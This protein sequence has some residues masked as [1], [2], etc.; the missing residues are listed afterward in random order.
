ML[1][2][3]V[4]F[5]L[6]VLYPVTRA[7]GACG[8]DVVVPSHGITTFVSPNYP[9]KYPNKA[10]C[11]YDIVAPA[12]STIELDSIFFMVEGGTGVT[13]GFDSLTVTETF[14]NGSVVVLGKFCSHSGPQSLRSATNRVVAT[15]RSDASW[16]TFGFNISARVPVCEPGSRLCPNSDTVCI[17][18]EQYC[19]GSENCPDGIDENEEKCQK[20]RCGRPAITPKTYHNYIGIHPRQRLARKTEI[21][22]RIV[23]GEES[24]PHSWPWQ[25]ALLDIR[26]GRQSCGGSIVSNEWILTAGHCCKAV[27]AA[28]PVPSDFKVLVG[29][30]VLRSSSQQQPFAEVIPLSQ[31]HIH[32]DYDKPLPFANDVCLLKL[33]KPVIFNEHIS[34]A[35]LS[36]GS[37]KTEQA[38][39]IVIGWGETEPRGP[40][41]STGP[42]VGETQATSLNLQQAPATI[43]PQETCKAS[44]RGLITADM[45]CAS[46]GPHSSCRGDSGGPLVCED[47]E[48]KFRLSGIV[49]WSK[50][51]SRPGNPSV[52][53]RVNYALPWIRHIIF[54]N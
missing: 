43:M 30:H 6:T 48:G 28:L 34:P 12:G 50:G 27:P 35:C 9:G 18:P 46:A 51:C 24:V 10:E 3:L 14:A 7:Q 40:F 29:A 49:S 21:P 54:T 8:G 5:V 52:Y 13:C 20:D 4:A 39:C 19:D 1:L 41:A 11:V 42:K 45:M 22:F 2:P 25:V 32:P 15:F 33:A 37:T 36:D 53:A 16:N 38:T 31:I 17:S 47:E 23:A 26:Q 44:Y